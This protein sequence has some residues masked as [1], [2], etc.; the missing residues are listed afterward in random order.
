MSAFNL[1]GIKSGN[2][3]EI[4][5]DVARHVNQA[6]VSWVVQQKTTEK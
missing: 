1:V 2:I 4:F 3:H 5:M 6:A